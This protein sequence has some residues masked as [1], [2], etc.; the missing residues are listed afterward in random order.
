MLGRSRMTIDPGILIVP[1]RSTSGFHRPGKTS[2]APTSKRREMFGAS[3]MKGR[4][5]LISGA[6]VVSESREGEGYYL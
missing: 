5:I 6:T 3:R 2:L 1:G 4:G